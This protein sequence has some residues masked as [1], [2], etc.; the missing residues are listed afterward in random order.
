[1][2][3]DFGQNLDSFRTEVVI[4]ATEPPRRYVS[5]PSRPQTFQKSKLHF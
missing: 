5:A 1:M 4:T 3:V 2:I